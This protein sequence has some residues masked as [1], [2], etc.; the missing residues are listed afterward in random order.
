MADCAGRDRTRRRDGEVEVA[1]A[2][3]NLGY[4]AATGFGQPDA[5]VPVT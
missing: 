3:G 5:T 4:E 2:C 1:Y